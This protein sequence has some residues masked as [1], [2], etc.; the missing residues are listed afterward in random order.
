MKTASTSKYIWL[1]FILVILGLLVW[2]AKSVFLIAFASIL[3]AIFLNAIGVWTKKITRLPYPVAMLFGISLLGALL[4]VSFWFYSPLIAEQFQG[5]MEQLPSAVGALKEEISHFVDLDQSENFMFNKDMLGYV[6][7][8]F[9]L[10]ITSL[11]NFVIFI[12]VGFYLALHPALYIGGY[13]KLFP[14]NK[15]ALAQEILVKITVTLKWWIFGKLIAM[16]S[17]GLLIYV[18][19]KIL[20]VSLAFILALL[21]GILAFIPYVG[22][23]LAAV[24]AILVG[25]AHSPLQALYITVVY[26]IVH[27][28]EG[29]LLTPVIEQKTV[30]LPPALTVLTQVLLAILAGGLGLA[31]ATPLTA[32]AL[33]LFELY[34]QKNSA[35]KIPA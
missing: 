27:L 21:A 28:A 26:L 1:S 30:F 3:L 9:S 14:R 6:T 25:F 16:L 8:V 17:I 2:V 31:L 7:K 4:S 22:S 12:F 24:P 11:V 10:T 23:I 18:G 32:V 5:L 35:F 34:R 33:A 15:Q 20:G 29:Y 19:L 13:F